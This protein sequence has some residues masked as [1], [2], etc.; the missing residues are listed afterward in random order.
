MKLVPFC[1]L[2]AIK[3]KK[4]VPNKHRLKFILHPIKIRMYNVHR[5]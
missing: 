3:Y 5:A 2:L 4:A 1:Y